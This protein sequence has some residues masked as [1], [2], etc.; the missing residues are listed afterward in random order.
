MCLIYMS[1]QSAVPAGTKY[2]KVTAI[3]RLKK[4][5][6]AS[7]MVML[8]LLSAHVMKSLLDVCTFCPCLYIHVCPSRFQTDGFSCCFVANICSLANEIKCSIG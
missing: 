8:T 7:L 4:H 1:Q 2:A 3:P 5:L 6:S